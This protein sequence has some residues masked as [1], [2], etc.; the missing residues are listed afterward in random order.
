MSDLGPPF[1]FT[2]L[3]KKD[4]T[5]IVNRTANYADP[6]AAP[7][8]ADLLLLSALGTSMDLAGTWADSGPGWP[9]LAQW[10][11]ITAQGR[12]HYVRVVHRGYLF[13]LGHPAVLVEIVER[14]FVADAIGQVTA[15]LQKKAF[16]KVSR[17]LKTYPAAGQPFG[18]HGWPF[19]SVLIA[20]SASPPLD[21]APP[22]QPP[23]QPFSGSD[24][25][26]GFPR[27]GGRDV[28]WTIV[29]TDAA[30][31]QV[32]LAVPLAFVYGG[33]SSGPNAASQYDVAY[34]TRLA[35]SYNDT[36]PTSL[37]PAS[38]RTGGTGGARLQFAPEAPG[39]PG[40]TTHPTTSIT[41]AAATTVSDPNA[42]GASVPAPTDQNMLR[43]D[44]QPA[45]YPS[46]AAARTRLPAAEALSKPPMGNPS[47]PGLDIALYQD[48]VVNGLVNK[49]GVYARSLA[50]PPLAFVGDAVGAVATPNFLISGLS[51]QAGAIGGPID[52]YAQNAVV[53]AS[54]YFSGLAGQLTGKLLGGLSLTDIIGTMAAP[55]IVNLVD[56]V[57]QVRTVHYRLDAPLRPVPGI[58]LPASPDGKLTMDAVATFDPGS[59][60]STYAVDGHIDSFTIQILGDGALHF[61]DIPFNGVHFT[62]AN[63]T[64]PDVRVDI[65]Q[66]QFAGALSFVNDLQ[67]FLK[68]LGGSGFSVNV[69]PTAVDAG[70][71]LALPSFGVG[72]FNMENLSLNA[73]IHVPFTGDGALA[74]FS[75]C[76]REHPFLLTVMCFG[77]GG[78]VGLGVGLSQ[79][80]LV[81]ASLEFGAQLALDIG[82]ASG[83][84]TVA[85]GVY[86][87]YDFQAGVELSGFVRITGELEVLGLIS[88]SAELDLELTYQ[89]KA[90]ND[91]AAKST[92]GGSATLRVEVSI[93]FFS[94]SVE[95]SVHREFAGGDPSFKDM[96]PDQLT[97]QAYCDAFAT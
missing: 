45:F 36:S 38:R 89:G 88:I 50:P 2:G 6:A 59:G 53:Q 85:A 5:D 79:V 76:T 12:D 39:H 25:Q 58:F 81:E 37:V 28:L 13:P 95:L 93:A 7:A 26:S 62:A 92:I 87:K 9:D 35:N 14:A 86:F 69:S 24:P 32:T 72:V 47:S 40:A 90:N 18:G 41:L 44:D 55:T 49:G 77:G 8:N 70:M 91:P 84:V 67:E 20:T 43:A 82:V 68:D 83:G 29:G 75:F 27:S 74:R 1:Q 3:T 61:I 17:P 15:Y 71:S 52:T 48:Y 16:I 19:T 97:W 94:T 80:E 66:V 73:G 46:L 4:R 56:Q 78:F 10:R 63:G 64:K 11:Q 65:G 33:E 96:V 31:N 23:L 42:P 57:T 54:E 21:Q 30:G 51:A 34:T 22:P 60:R